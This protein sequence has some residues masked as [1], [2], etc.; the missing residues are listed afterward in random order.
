MKIYVAK[1]SSERYK[2]MLQ[3]FSDSL[4]EINLSE[5]W[6]QHDIDENEFFLEQYLKNKLGIKTNE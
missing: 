6:N 3:C 2:A 1:P 5:F 4:I